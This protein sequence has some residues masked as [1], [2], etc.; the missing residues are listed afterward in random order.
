V[1][2]FIIGPYDL[3]G[4]LGV[5]GQFDHPKVVAALKR[6]HKIAKKMKALSGYHIIP[7]DIHVFEAKKSEG[8]QFIAYSID[9]LF[10]GHACRNDI[11]KIKESRA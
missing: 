1:D 6:V 8:Y 5:P 7:P 4:S 9:I 10:L 2:G 3:S 11:L